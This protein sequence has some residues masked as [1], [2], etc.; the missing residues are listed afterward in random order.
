MIPVMTLQ[1]DAAVKVQKAEATELISGIR[2]D[3]M[4]GIERSGRIGRC[5]I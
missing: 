2:P 3:I 5:A 4:E 1:Q